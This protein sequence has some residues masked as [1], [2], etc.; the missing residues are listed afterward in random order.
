MVRRDQVGLA[1]SADELSHILIASPG[2]YAAL[3]TSLG[4]RNVFD[5]LR[6][7]ICGKDG[8]TSIDINIFYSTYQLTKS[9]S[10]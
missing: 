1:V 8:L 6:K 3:V 10:V 5:N 9:E 2:R 7:I 4:R